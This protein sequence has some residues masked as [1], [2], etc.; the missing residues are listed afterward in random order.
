[1]SEQLPLFR[2]LNID[3]SQFFIFEFLRISA[4]LKM[5]H[6]QTKKY[7]HY[8]M[9]DGLI[10]ALEKLI[11]RFVESYLS[12]SEK[13]NLLRNLV[14]QTMRIYSIHDTNIK[15]FLKTIIYFLQDLNIPGKNDDLCAIRDE[16]LLYVNQAIYVYHLH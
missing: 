2:S 4:Q 8:Q 9:L 3:D 5:Y 7:S 15:D 10:L 14:T 11:D 6:W 1:M 16:M 13:K 12:N